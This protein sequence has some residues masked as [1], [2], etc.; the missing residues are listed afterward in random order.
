MNP[1]GLID[2]L[3]DAQ[4]KRA[5]WISSGA[6]FVHGTDLGAVDDAPFRQPALAGGY[7]DADG[8]SG[9]LRAIGGD[10]DDGELG[11]KL[12]GAIV[13]DDD[14]GP[15]LADLRADGGVEDNLHDVPAVGE[16]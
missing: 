7:F 11:A 4:R 13:G 10:R 9:L 12:V 1:Q 5:Q 16:E 14:T 15:G 3:Q 2:L 8:D 6:L